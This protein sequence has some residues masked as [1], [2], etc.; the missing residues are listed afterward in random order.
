L[1]GGP[2]R[3]AGTGKLGDRGIR[4]LAAGVR[5]AD[6]AKLHG[7]ETPASSACRPAARSRTLTRSRRAVR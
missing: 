5:L 7:W 6:N 1:T 3:G 4:K 2:N